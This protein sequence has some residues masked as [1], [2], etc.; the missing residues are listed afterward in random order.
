[1]GG[2]ILV[3]Y[4]IVLADSIDEGIGKNY[5]I[6]DEA[7]EFLLEKT[8]VCVGDYYITQDYEKY[9]IIAL[10]EDL[11][12]GTARL[13]AKLS[14]PN[15][16]INPYPTP[17]YTTEDKVICLY[18]THNDE[19]YVPTDGVDSVYGKGGIHDVTKHLANAL[20]AQGIT[21]YIDETLHIPH[22]SSAYSRSSITCRNMINQYSP[23]AIFDIHRDGTSR[24]YYVHNN[25]GIEECMVRIV[26]GKSNS[27]MAINEEFALYI[28]AVANEL[29]PGLIKDIY[30]ASGHY[31]QGQY[32]KSLLFE[33][34]SHMVEK[35]LVMK[36][37]EKLA[38]VINTA[39][40]STTVDA[41]SG[42]IDI[43]DVPTES[44]PT[45]DQVLDTKIQDSTNSTNTGVIF[46]LLAWFGLL[47]GVLWLIIKVSKK[48]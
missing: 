31:N 37:A 10:N 20:R 2:I 16:S 4:N 6:F 42:E 11:C 39:M 36:S 13:L 26:L 1:M 18:M 47:G 7:G 3:P 45:I 33:M 15:I 30:Y 29:Y 19:S 14:K 46:R 40:F 12:I 41:E 35:E 23:N 34:G 43:F 21:T 32:A 38:D 44:S 17:I 48:V 9:E 27:N 8:D 5:I 28:M 22:N 25:N 24:A